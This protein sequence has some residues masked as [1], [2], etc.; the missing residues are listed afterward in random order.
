LFSL[1]ILIE[2]AESMNRTTNPPSIRH[3]VATLQTIVRRA[4]S[5]NIGE[6]VAQWRLFNECSQG[7]LQSFLK[8]VNS[9]GRREDVCLSEFFFI[10]TSPL[11]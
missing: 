7:F 3:I 8:T 6:P 9:L 11:I 5:P 2:I 4:R 1:F 10:L